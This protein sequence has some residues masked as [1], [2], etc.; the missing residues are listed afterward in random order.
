M[1][2]WK[3]SVPSGNSFTFPYQAQSPTSYDR[4]QF[5]TVDDVWVEV[6]KLVIESRESTRSIGQDLFF[7]LP[8]FADPRVILENWHFE[9]INEWQS[10]KMLGLPIAK[11]LDEADAMK[12]DGFLIIENEMLSISKYENKKKK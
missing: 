10:S 7:L 1:W 4:I 8:M 6:E 5:D 3:Y 2:F 12:V 11:T 9:M